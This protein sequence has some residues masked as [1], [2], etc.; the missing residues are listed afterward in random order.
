MET[1]NDLDVR[2]SAERLV[3]TIRA[4]GSA[5]VALSGGVDST[6]VAMAARLALA[7]RAVA[8]TGTSASLAAGE[9][10]ETRRLAERIG[11]RHHVV[12]TDEFADPD[13]VKNDGRRCYFCKS[14]LYDRLLSLR[15]ELGFDVVCS[16]ANLDDQGDYRPGL[17][18]AAQRQV[19]HPL[20]EAGFDKARVR[21][22]A[23]LWELPNQ[24]KPAM[25]CLASRLAI[26]VEVT[27]ERTG[28]VDQAE[29]FLRDLGCTRIRVRCHP[30]EHARIEVAPEEIVR[31]AE[32]T[33][34]DKIVDR[35]RELGF[36]F[37]SLDLEGFRS[38]GL[39]ILVPEAAQESATR[40]D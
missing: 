7:D 32:P 17:T 13:Y 10:E 18:A 22:V 19:R 40:V 14:E 31:I 36:A 20:Q 12:A 9:L 34:R 38:G 24:D 16:G 21:A 4:Y 2:S 39:N 35:F 30:G 11:I 5:A 3:N 23:Q 1:P 33:V 28:K 27:P 37:V 8:V 29:R 25:P 15:E 26:G 6:V